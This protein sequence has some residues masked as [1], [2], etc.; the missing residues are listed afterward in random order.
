MKRLLI[1]L[2]SWGGGYPQ[3]ISYKRYFGNHKLH[4]LLKFVNGPCRMDPLKWARP[5]LKKLAENTMG[6]TGVFLSP[7]NKWSF[8]PATITGDG[9]HFVPGNS[10]KGGLFWHHV[11]FM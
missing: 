6:F 5:L 10:G 8:N 2:A 7:Q 9:T 4:S 3:V 11:E 1:S